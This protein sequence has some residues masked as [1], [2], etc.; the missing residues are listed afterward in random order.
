MNYI[1]HNTIQTKRLHWFI[2]LYFILLT[3]LFIFESAGFAQTTEEFN[4]A[5][6][7]TFNVPDGVL[8]ITVEA[9]GAGGGGGG[10]PGSGFAYARGGGGGAYAKTENISVQPGQNYAIV[11]GQGG[12][13]GAAGANAGSDGENSTFGS[14]PLVQAAGGS[15]GLAATSGAGGLGGTTA[16][17]IG[18]VLFRGGNAFIGGGGGAGSGGNGGDTNDNNGGEG[19]ATGGGDGGSVELPLFG[20]N[21]GNPGSSYG[22]GGSGAARGFFGQAQPGGNGA[23]G[24][25][26]ITY[27]VL[28]ADLQITKT[29]DDATPNV[30]DVVTFTVTVINNGPDDATGVTVEDAL[31]AGYGSVTNISNGGTLSGNVITWSGLSI[32]NGNTLSLSFDAE[33]LPP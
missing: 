4:T 9:W 6:T 25:V 32:N 19:T 22:G 15:G 17:S 10:R 1:K 13:G 8:S 33:I 16:A 23:D 21:P 31:P 28:E 27:T 7:Y 18:D 2:L 12:T 26:H 5:G 24:A 14:G 20:S 11:V 29:V 3:F 30:G